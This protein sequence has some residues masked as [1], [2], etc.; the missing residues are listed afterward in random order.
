MMPGDTSL[1]ADQCTYSS[2]ERRR[3]YIC[4]YL[5]LF[6]PGI[7]TTISAREA[8]VS[9]H[10]GGP[11]EG[12]PETPR[13]SQTN[14][15]EGFKEGAVTYDAERFNSFIF[16]VVSNDTADIAD[17]HKRHMFVCLLRKDKNSKEAMREEMEANPAGCARQRR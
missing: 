3:K 1:S 6:F 2:L 12:P 16:K 14:G 9:R 7:F 15:T 11:I 4:N 8:A 17:V 13:T 10:H 5:P